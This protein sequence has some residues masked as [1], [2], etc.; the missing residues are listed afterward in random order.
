MTAEHTDISWYRAV[1]GALGV[2]PLSHQ[3]LSGGC[4]APVYR[5]DLMNGSSAVAKLGGGA[6][7]FGGLELE[8]EMLE[9]L[10]RESALPVPEVYLKTENL[11]LMEFL[12][13]GS[14]IG[15]K[16]QQHAAELLAALH[17]ILGPD[18]G[19]LGFGFEYDT[20]IGGLRQP[21]PWTKSWVEFFRDQRLI[22]MARGAFEAGRL[23]FSLLQRVERLGERLDDLIDEP[24]HPSLIHGD[25]WTGNVLVD[26]PR[27]SGFV[28]PAVC[29]ADAE[30][31]LAFSTLF[32]TFGVSFFKRYNEIRPIA[33]GFF[34]LRLD[35]YNLWHL[36]T[37]VRLFGGS[38]V[39]SVDRILRRHG[40]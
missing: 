2:R 5:V 1:E 16:S 8:G 38:Y 40:L 28:D 12:A 33:D 7:T 25:M 10:A 19:R 36:L 22:Y 21:N 18:Y 29:Y 32:G 17:N 4:V 35:I 20:V 15:D 30:I 26:G 34:D 13:G 6:G 3:P 9:F 37:H 23:E 24:L 14:P 27:V 11:L 31:E 39:G